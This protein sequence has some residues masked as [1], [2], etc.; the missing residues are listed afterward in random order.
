MKEFFIATPWD[1]LVQASQLLKIVAQL[2]SALF[3]NTSTSSHYM[4]A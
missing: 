4:Q 1:L 2:C 3:T